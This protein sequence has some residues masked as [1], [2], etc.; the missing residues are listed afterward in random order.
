MQSSGTYPGPQ[1]AFIS[2]L[3]IQRIAEAVRSIIVFDVQTLVTPLKNQISAL[4][5]ENLEL[6]AWEIDDLEMYSRRDCI[7]VA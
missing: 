4:Q 1:Q 3:G 6:R 7:R 5:N 2:Y